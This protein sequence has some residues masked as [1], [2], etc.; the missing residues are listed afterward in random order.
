MTPEQMKLELE[1]AYRCI[2]GLYKIVNE[3]PTQSA[4]LAYH[5]LTIAAAKRFV[6]LGELDGAEYFIGKSVDE[7]TAAMILPEVA[8]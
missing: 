6:Y 3:R 5:R 1:N 2:Q 4:T 8:K 7:L